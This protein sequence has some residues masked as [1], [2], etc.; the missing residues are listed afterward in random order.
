MLWPA[1]FFAQLEF[2]GSYV[3]CGSPLIWP[4]GVV[5]HCLQLVAGMW[6]PYLVALCNCV[7]TGRC[8]TYVADEHVALVGRHVMCTYGIQQFNSIVLLL[9]KLLG[10]VSAP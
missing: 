9:D 3:A 7:L 2:P 4:V 6:L 8:C 1:G 5:H 10:V